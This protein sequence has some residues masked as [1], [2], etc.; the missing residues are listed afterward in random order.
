M[1]LN[2]FAS[3]WRPPARIETQLG[4]LSIKQGSQGS[5]RH[6]S[7]SAPQSIAPP[8]NG[9][10]KRAHRQQQQQQQP[11]QQAAQ[12]SGEVHDSEELQFEDGFERHSSTAGRDDGSGASTP[13]ALVGPT[14]LP[15]AASSPLTGALLLAAT[16][17]SEPVNGGRSCFGGGGAGADVGPC[18]LEVAETI[19]VLSVTTHAAT[20]ADQQVEATSGKRRYGP[21]DFELLRVVGQG[22]FGKVF[23]VRKRDTGEIFAMKV[24]RKARIVEK[25]HGDYVK[26]ERDILTSVLHPYIVTLRY[27]FQTPHKLYLVLDFINGGHLFFQ[28]YRQG[29]F[30]EPL[31]R[32]YAAEIVLAI[33]H[34]H[35][36][37]FVHR[38]LKPENVLLDS[39]GHIRVSDFGLAKG[40]MQSEETRSNSFIGTMEYMSPEI[41]AGRGH[42]KSADWWSVGVLLYEML[43]GVAPFRAKGRNALQK[44]ITNGKAKFPS[45][46][47]TEALSLLKGLLQKDPSKRL[48]YGPG[49]SAEVMGHAFFRHVDWKKLERREVPSPFKPSTVGGKASIENFDKLYTDLPVQ[50]SPCPTP[51]DSLSLEDAIFEGFSYV[52][53]SFLAE[54]AAAAGDNGTEASLHHMASIPE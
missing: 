32:L 5:G 23:Q 1:P 36:L 26:A 7:S 24:M 43:C 2:P 21:S 42:S 39:E 6:G 18:P 48:G 9:S 33:A 49:G 13:R 44:L 51:R 15:S 4:G 53:P 10:R 3:E 29:T 47:S 14:P 31:A 38:D 11:D 54:A 22:A 16:E 25:D 34:L 37:G 52:A 35:S 45:Y 17:G 19:P 28:L 27:S 41:I 50:D 40:K 46:L 8:S 30:D 20:E 12:S